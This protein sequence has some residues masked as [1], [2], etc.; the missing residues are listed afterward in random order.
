MVASLSTSSDYIYFSFHHFFWLV[1]YL[2]S[3]LTVTVG[4]A[5]R[6]CDVA[7]SHRVCHCCSAK[8]ESYKAE[9]LVEKISYIKDE[10]MKF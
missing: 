2:F 9:I 7:E 3:Y 10:L 6:R 4:L 5:W 1:L 8:E